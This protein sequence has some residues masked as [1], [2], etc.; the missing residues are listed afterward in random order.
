[1]AVG[2]PTVEAAPLHAVRARQSNGTPYLGEHRDMAHLARMCR[3]QH[4]KES[5]EA[6]AVEGD[7]GR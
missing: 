4:S 3:S 1:M 7:V 2:A 6:K 5:K